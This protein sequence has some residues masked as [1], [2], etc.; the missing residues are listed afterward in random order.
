[1]YSLKFKDLNINHLVCSKLWR[2]WSMNY[3]SHS[4]GKNLET[5]KKTRSNLPGFIS[6]NHN[7][8]YSFTK[9]N[10]KSWNHL[11]RNLSDPND[12]NFPCS[13]PKR[14]TLSPSVHVIIKKRKTHILCIWWKVHWQ[15]KSGPST[16]GGTC[17]VHFSLSLMQN[18]YIF[19]CVV[20]LTLRMLHFD[21]F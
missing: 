8:K 19:T 11:I 1:M 16:Q 13:S 12:I 14:V 3:Y 9:M 10:P 18:S 20:T 2:C 21:T 17:S 7:L 5:L 15:D 6:F 4:T